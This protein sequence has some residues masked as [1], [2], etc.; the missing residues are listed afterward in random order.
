MKIENK[1]IIYFADPMLGAGSEKIE[2]EFKWI[3]LA[4]NNRDIEIE[5]DKVKCTHIPPF[6]DQFDILFFDWGGMSFGND[7]LGSFCRQI[8]RQAEDRPNTLYVIVSRMSEHAMEDAKETLGK[9]P[10][11]IFMNLDEFAEYLNKYGV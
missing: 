11:N 9:A 8:L 7:M 5:T 2:D 10:E 1:K 3:A 4:L 6:E